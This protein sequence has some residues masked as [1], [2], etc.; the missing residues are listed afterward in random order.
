MKEVTKYVEIPVLNQCIQ[1][2]GGKRVDLQLLYSCIEYNCNVAIRYSDVMEW[3]HD[4]QNLKKPRARAI[5]LAA[6]SCKY[7][8]DELLLE[9]VKSINNEFDVFLEASLLF[10]AYDNEAV[11][12][13]KDSLV[14]TE[15]STVF[16]YLFAASVLDFRGQENSIKAGVLSRRIDEGLRVQNLSIENGE[17]YAVLAEMVTRGFESELGKLF[18]RAFKNQPNENSIILQNFGFYGYKLLDV[19]QIVYYGLKTATRLEIVKS[20][21][22][23][24]DKVT[25]CLLNA[26][27]KKT[28][29]WSKEERDQVKLILA[30]S[31]IDCSEVVCDDNRIFLLSLF[32]LFN[33]NMFIKNTVNSF[34]LINKD[35]LSILPYSDRSKLMLDL[36]SD[37]MAEILACD[38]EHDEKYSLRENVLNALSTLNGWRTSEL[39]MKYIH[40]PNYYS[41]CEDESY[42]VSE[43]L[44][45][46]VTKFLELNGLSDSVDDLGD[47]PQYLKSVA[48]DKFLIK[49]DV[50]KDSMVKLLSSCSDCDVPRYVFD[51]IINNPWYADNILLFYNN[52]C[53]ACAN[54]FKH[55]F[56]IVQDI[57][58]A[59]HSL[60]G[61]RSTIELIRW[62]ALGSTEASW[63]NDL[64]LWFP[65]N[66][67]NYVSRFEKFTDFKMFCHLFNEFGVDCT[68]KVVKSVTAYYGLP[69]TVPKDDKSLM[70]LLVWLQQSG[71]PYFEAIASIRDWDAISKDA[72]CKSK[73]YLS[74]FMQEEPI[75][76]MNDVLL[77]STVDFNSAGRITDLNLLAQILS[78]DNYSSICHNSHYTFLD[79]DTEALIEFSKVFYD[80]NNVIDYKCMELNSPALTELCKA[81]SSSM[82]LNNFRYNH[83]ITQ[84]SRV[85]GLLRLYLENGNLP[86]LKD[87][88][89]V[90]GNEVISEWKRISSVDLRTLLFASWDA[91]LS[92]FNCNK[93][94][95]DD[96]S[97]VLAFVEDKLA[98]IAEDFD[99][100]DAVWSFA[101]RFGAGVYVKGSYSHFIRVY[102][103]FLGTGIE[104]LSDINVLCTTASN[105][106]M[107]N[108]MCSLLEVTC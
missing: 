96:K 95:I 54:V 23:R 33:K 9:I 99:V 34:Y 90:F 55:D 1:I 82:D 31:D 75:S 50:D 73:L 67:R 21:E 94:C 3:I 10:L 88:S 64:L 32:G 108:M 60:K 17:C 68:R 93:I 72:I 105:F 28:S 71:H 61:T 24:K 29:A 46:F 22:S 37:K 69:K 19:A 16:E 91:D 100:D 66:E 76:K 62:R 15:R 20:S 58:L 78:R 80:C 59:D 86:W 74:L 43:N 85:A 40:D 79:N 14:F 41:G 13:A 12:A 102:N 97:Y 106:M 18:L 92:I 5:A 47:V 27:F 2:F 35:M 83:D 6:A 81:K 8:N 107:S 4:F 36:E 48:C 87:G 49:M 63:R 65:E 38:D 25:A 98:V 7:Y 104:W 26:L 42:P 101:K 89:D 56:P 52:Q 39:K 84:K 30:S 53:F 44:D 51:V 77:M 57:V 70:P 11:D 45:G 103:S